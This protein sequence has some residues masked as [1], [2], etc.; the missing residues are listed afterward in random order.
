MDGWRSAFKNSGARRAGA[1]PPF[2]LPEGYD[3]W[4]CRGFGWKAEQVKYVIWSNKKWDRCAFPYHSDANG[5]SDLEYWEAVKDG[6]VYRDLVPGEIIRPGDEWFDDSGSPA[7]WK[8]RD[9]IWKEKYT[10]G[11]HTPHRRKL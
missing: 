11:H 7:C 2:D 3:R 9:P 4:V 6:P 10:P 5:I 1:L 8:L